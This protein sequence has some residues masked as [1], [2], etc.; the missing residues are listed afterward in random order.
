MRPR[1]SPDVSGVPSGDRW[2]SLVVHGLPLRILGFSLV[3]FGDPWCP[4]R[5]IACPCDFLGSNRASQEF[6]LGY[7]GRAQ[8]SKDSL[9]L[10]LRCA[11]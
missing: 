8:V 7:L 1:V 6:A 3:I 11:R 9:W 4:R 5:A 10:P 2:L